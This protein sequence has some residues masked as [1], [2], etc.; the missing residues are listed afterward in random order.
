VQPNW[1]DGVLVSANEAE[2]AVT[3]Y[4]DWRQEVIFYEAPGLRGIGSPLR[5][6]ILTIF[7]RLG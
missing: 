5:R 7:S 6:R 2:G 1:L 4:Y 3:V